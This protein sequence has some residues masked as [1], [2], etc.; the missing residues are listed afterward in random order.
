MLKSDKT[1]AQERVEKNMIHQSHWNQGF[2]V[3]VYKSKY[4]DREHCYLE[5]IMKGE[6]KEQEKTS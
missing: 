4:I 1:E 3:E 2:G 6:K 5:K